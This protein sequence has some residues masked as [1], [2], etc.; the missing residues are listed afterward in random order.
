[1]SFEDPSAKKNPPEL[2]GA[3]DM[4]R[5][6]YLEDEHVLDNIRTRFQKQEMYT[7]MSTI[8]IAVNPYQWLPVYGADQIKLYYNNSK[9]R[10]PDTELPLHIYGVAGAAYRDMFESGQS[11]SVLVCGESGAGKTE[12]AKKV[13]HYLTQTTQSKTGEH[14]LEDQLMA[15]NPIMESFGNAKT[16]LNNNSS[17]FGKFTKM[18][19]AGSSFESGHIAGVQI[20]TYLLEKSRVTLQAIGERNFH[21]FYQICRVYSGDSR[22]Q[23][24]DPSKFYYLDQTGRN[25]AYNDVDGISDTEWHN[26]VK[27]A[28]TSFNVGEQ[29]QQDLFAVVAGL[30]HLG[31][32]KFEAIDDDS[33]KVDE[34]TA[35]H[36]AAAADLLGIDEDRLRA[37]L[38]S[39]TVKVDGGITTLLSAE[40]ARHNRDAIAQELYTGLFGYIVSCLNK[41]MVLQ[42]STGKELFIGILDIA[43]F[44][45]FEHNSFEQFCINFANEKLQQFFNEDV[46]KNE[47]EEYL[48]EGVYWVPLDIPNNDAYISLVQHKTRGLFSLLDAACR[49]PKATSETFVNNLFQTHKRH[50][51]MRR[52][53]SRPG[54]KKDFLGFAIKHYAGKVV[55]DCDEFLDKVRFRFERFALR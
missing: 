31:N 41:E 5:L 50:S 47:Q 46:I 13:M 29:T 12:S 24:A 32:I 14:R 22:F 40:K 37:R 4:T 27:E 8:L 11:Q 28:L 33:C 17:R 1:M 51:H 53:G 25:A 44:E 6:L 9:A 10:V 35:K 55:Y 16:V 20:E 45:K 19:F 30:L 48:N 49:T 54:S 34:S 18:M 36:V 42:R 26:E 23:M 3:H 2:D 52:A 43:G 38:T 7:S 15:G 39:A 21:I